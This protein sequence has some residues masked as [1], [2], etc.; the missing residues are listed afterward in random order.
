MGKNYSTGIYKKTYGGEYVKTY[1]N[2]RNNKA[3][4]EQRR[5]EYETISKKLESKPY[6]QSEKKVYEAART[7]TDT[8]NVPKKE[9]I[10]PPYN[11]QSEFKQTDYSKIDVNSLKHPII[12]VGAGAYRNIY[13]GETVNI[14]EARKILEYA[15]YRPKPL[16]NMGMFFLFLL[17]IAI[18]LKGVGPIA[19]IAWGLISKSKHMTDYIKMV[20]TNVL[21]FQMPASDAER[22]AYKNRGNMYIGAGI[23]VGLIQIIMFF[24]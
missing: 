12:S 24:T 10:P 23:M 11:P 9:Q 18:L 6:Q 16:A 20:R 14:E 8:L 13:T 1:E 21:V 15:G 7:Q 2:Y 5:K 4:Y 3:L 19:L 22:Q 17:V